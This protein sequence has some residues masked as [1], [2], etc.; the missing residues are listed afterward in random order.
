VYL[1]PHLPGIFGWQTAHWINWLEVISPNG[2]LAVALLDL[3]VL[4]LAVVGYLLARHWSRRENFSII[5]LL[6]FAIVA[7]TLAFAELHAVFLWMKLTKISLANSILKKA[8]GL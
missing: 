7:V 4:M 3:L 5:G 2:W 6:P 8:S 1:L